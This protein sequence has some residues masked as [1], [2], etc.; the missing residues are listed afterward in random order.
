[1]VDLR[2]ASFK[3]VTRIHRTLFDISK[4]R[5]LARASGMPVVK[6]TTTGRKSQTPRETMLTTPVH[7]QGKVVLV[8]SY[9]GSDRHPSWYLNLRAEPNVTITMDGHQRRM[10]ART[11]SPEEKA[12][13]WPDIVKANKGYAG[14]QEKTNRDIPV[15][16]LEP[17]SSPAP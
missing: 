10:V 5:F 3:T 13:L 4:G 1:M 15:V 2:E 17:S 6:L 7:D 16:I 8:A 12:Q 9:G 14:Y 11:A